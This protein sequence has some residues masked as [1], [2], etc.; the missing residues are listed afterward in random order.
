MKKHL[1]VYF[2]KHSKFGAFIESDQ[3]RLDCIDMSDIQ[4]T[5]QEN[6]FVYVI[7]GTP[8]DFFHLGQRW[9]DYQVENK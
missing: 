3:L 7:K 6:G 5:E 2:S 8:L 9:M 1:E 4:I